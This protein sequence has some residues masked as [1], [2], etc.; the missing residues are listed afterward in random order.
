MFPYGLS[1]TVSV[2]TLM[3]IGWLIEAMILQEITFATKLELFQNQQAWENLTK[4]Y[5]AINKFKSTATK[6]KPPTEN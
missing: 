3:V 5:G 4:F 2:L 1:W 6:P